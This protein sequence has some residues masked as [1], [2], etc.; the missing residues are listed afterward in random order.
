MNHGVAVL[1]EVE[2]LL[3]DLDRGQHER[4][5][6]RIE[7]LTH[8]AIGLMSRAQLP[9]APR[10]PTSYNGAPGRRPARRW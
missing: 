5:E 7:R 2:A 9:R 3:T 10:A 1:L 8:N 6:G 4:P